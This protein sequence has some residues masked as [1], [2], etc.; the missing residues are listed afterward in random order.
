MQVNIFLSKEATGTSNLQC[1]T[2]TVLF[3]NQT[4]SSLIALCPCYQYP[5]GHCPKNYNI[6]CTSVSTKP[7]Q[8]TL[9]TVFSHQIL[10]ITDL[11]VFTDSIQS[12]LPQTYF[13]HDTKNQANCW[14]YTG[15]KYIYCFSLCVR[16]IQLY[17][18]KKQLKQIRL[19]KR[20][21]G[22]L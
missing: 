1:L 20:I 7:V 15:K 17:I 3:T 18:T 9:L 14:V 22:H 16:T 10:I 12:P 2:C 8:C 21:W 6:I 11:F 5:L 13:L 4:V 19:R